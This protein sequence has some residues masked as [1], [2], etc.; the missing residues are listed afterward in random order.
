MAYASR[1]RDGGGGG[2]MQGQRGRHGPSRGRAVSGPEAGG[3]VLGP[4]A[5]VLKGFGAGSTGGVGVAAPAAAPSRRPYN[6]GPAG[7]GGRRNGPHGG[8]GRSVSYSVTSQPQQAWPQLNSATLGTFKTANPSVASSG[9]GNDQPATPTSPLVR[10]SASPI[11]APEDFPVLGGAPKSAGP[12][13]P[14]IAWGKSDVASKIAAPPSKNDMGGEMEFEDL[15][16]DSSEAAEIARLKALVPK[17]NAPKIPGKQAMG[18]RERSKSVALAKAPIP[19]TTK[20][21]VLIKAA[22]MPTKPMPT[23]INHVA[24][25]SVAPNGPTSTAAPVFIANRPKLRS[26]MKASPRNK[27]AFPASMDPQN[28]SQGQKERD[29]LHKSDSG[30]GEWTSCNTSPTT[31][32]RESRSASISSASGSDR[33]DATSPL[34]SQDTSGPTSPIGIDANNV[35][36]Q[37]DYNDCQEDAEV[38]VR[39]QAS[40]VAESEQESWETDAAIIGESPQGVNGDDH[41]PALSDGSSRSTTPAMSAPGTPG[42]NR[43]DTPSDVESHPDPY[44]STFQYSASLER[45]EQFLRSLGW[46]KSAYYDSDVDESEYVITEEEKK[47]FWDGVGKTLLCGAA[48]SAGIFGGDDALGSVF[49]AGPESKRLKQH[50]IALKQTRTKY[51][52]INMHV[53]DHS[54]KTASDDYFSTIA[55]ENV[56]AVSWLRAI[57]DELPIEEMVACH[58]TDWHSRFL[59]NIGRGG[60]PQE[61]QALQAVYNEFKNALEAKR[62]TSKASLAAIEDNATQ[63][64]AA[65]QNQ[66]RRKRKHSSGAHSNSEHMKKSRLP[67]P[68]ALPTAPDLTASEGPVDGQDTVAGSSDSPVRP[69]GMSFPSAT[70]NDSRTFQPYTE[71]RRLLEQIQENLR[72]LFSMQADNEPVADKKEQGVSE[73][74]P[75]ETP[76]PETPD[77]PVN[78]HGLAKAIAAIDEVHRKRDATTTLYWNILDLRREGSLPMADNPRLADLMTENDNTS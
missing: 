19:T 35:D 25:P 68:T 22:P 69:E 17:L 46:D 51:P 36:E 1:A 10:S 4:G 60:T 66:P 5:G 73:T 11:V 21:V 70:S 55:A 26:T 18:S 27:A 77:V 42:P 39:S 7:N 63:I 32:S 29:S 9:S 57:A 45:E 76:P 64:C 61:F 40:S 78:V 33:D 49:D 13:S 72:L 62:M 14:V 43:D 28:A 24:R 2:G 47:E 37:L 65:I 54:W 53:P 75:P 38:E 30:V 15:Y 3:I 23:R 50:R 56:S 8:G 74:T 44:A 12:M 41:F 16:H 52:V 20:P 58:A 6:Q 48:A 71:P 31:T 67:T 34:N 59:N